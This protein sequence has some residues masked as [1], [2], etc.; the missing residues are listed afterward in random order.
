MLA[1]FFSFVNIRKMYFNRRKRSGQQSI[2]NGNTGMGIRRWIDQNP[3]K[4]LGRLSDQI[5][6]LAFVIGLLNFK[7][8]SKAP[9]FTQKLLIDLCDTHPSVDIHLTGSQQI[10]IR[11]VDDKDF[12]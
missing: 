11:A 2:P 1:K 10:Q 4:G 5:N 3:F 6:D 9:G 7:A 12:E 8:D